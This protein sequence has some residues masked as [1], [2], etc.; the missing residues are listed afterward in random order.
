MSVLY[1]IIY[2]TAIVLGVVFVLLLLQYWKRVYAVISLFGVKIQ[3]ALSRVQSTAPA[4][5][6]VVVAQ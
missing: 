2:P 5:P 1:D 6:D 3:C 4:V